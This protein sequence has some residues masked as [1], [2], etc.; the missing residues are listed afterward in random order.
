M[1]TLTSIH[2]NTF[3]MEEADLYSIH[4]EP[5]FA[6]NQRAFLV[7]TPEGNVL[8]DCVALLDD[9][10][11]QKIRA[12]GG[13]KAIAVSHPHYYT[14]MVEWSRAFG[15]APIYLHSLNKDWVMRPDKAIRFWEGETLSLPGGLTL[16]RTGGHFDGFQVLHWPDGAGGKGLL[17]AGDQPEVCSARSWVTFMYSYPNYIPLGPAAIKR[18]L[19]ALQP[20]SFDRLYGAFPG[21]TVSANAK[22]VV[23]RSAARY[24]DAI[25][26]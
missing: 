15:D 2:R 13:L 1:E 10:T 23:E 24:L 4:M 16:I 25:A 9:V 19:R 12:C 11:R 21:R 22:R 3:E 26:I 14:T 8:W 18:I 7:R 6:I 17:L 20:F 5:S